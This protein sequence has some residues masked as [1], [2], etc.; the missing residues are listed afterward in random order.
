[1]KL[2]FVALLMGLVALPCLT[3]ASDEAPASADIARNNILNTVNR[4]TTFTSKNQ[5]YQILQGVVAA[6]GLS[7][8]L[9]QQTLA[10]LGSS[11]QIIETKGSYVVYKSSQQ[12]ALAVSNTITSTTFPTVVNKQ[13]GVTGILPGTITVKLKNTSNSINIAKAH[14]L[15]LVKEFAHLQTAFFSVKAGQDVVAAAAT[16]NA[17]SSVIS[18]EVEVIE[19]VRVPN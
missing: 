3:Q 12:T 6:K 15:T 1:M 5:Q 7:N 8:E 2:F 19:H 10:R 14:G 16:L 9:P 18:A 4:G 11:G 17:D 13:T